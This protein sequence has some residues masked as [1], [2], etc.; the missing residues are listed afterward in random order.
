MTTKTPKDR[1]RHRKYM[2]DRYRND[3]EHRAKH[4]ARVKANSAR[5]REEVRQLVEEFRVAGCLV[6]GEVEPCC[7]VAHHL[8]SSEKDFNIGGAV[9]KRISPKKVRIEL[10]K[11]VCLCANCHAKVHAGLI[12]LAV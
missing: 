8:D 9:N 12:E 6:C 2:R 11:C 1:E 4:L 10:A 3:P 5:Y 7:L